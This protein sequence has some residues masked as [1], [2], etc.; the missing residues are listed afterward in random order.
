MLHTGCRVQSPLNPLLLLTK[1]SGCTHEF[2]SAGFVLKPHL[3]T[4]GLNQLSTPQY[5]TVG[6]SL[7]HVLLGI[8]RVQVKKTGP[9]GLELRP[10]IG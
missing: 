3:Q 5:I 6:I 2:H 4:L 8:H 9:S 1:L 7:A 10:S